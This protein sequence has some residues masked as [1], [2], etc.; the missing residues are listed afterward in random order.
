MYE[1]RDTCVRCRGL[2]DRGLLL[3]EQ[4]CRAGPNASSTNPW[5]P[6]AAAK[7][8]C[9]GYLAAIQDPEIF[10]AR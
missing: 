4:C 9:P 5:K 2:G 6:W 7:T 8:M 10:D 1:T 3:S